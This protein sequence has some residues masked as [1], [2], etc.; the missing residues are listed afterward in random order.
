MPAADGVVRAE[1][2]IAQ[3]HH[4]F[5]GLRYPGQVVRAVAADEVAW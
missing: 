4:C 2:V 3:H 1:D 5:R